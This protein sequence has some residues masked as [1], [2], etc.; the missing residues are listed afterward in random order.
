MARIYQKGF[1]SDR[2]SHQTALTE[3]HSSVSKSAAS[4][5]AVGRPMNPRPKIG[6]P[7]HGVRGPVASPVYRPQSA[8]KAV[9]RKLG[10]GA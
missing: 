2:A 5:R 6:L 9:Q 1:G 7:A 10:N 8:P 3:S 4:T